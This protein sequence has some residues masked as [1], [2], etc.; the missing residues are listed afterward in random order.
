MR[1][2]KLKLNH[3]WSLGWLPL[4]VTFLMLSGCHTAM[5]TDGFRSL[6]ISSS[7]DLRFHSDFTLP[8]DHPLISELISQKLTVADK[9]G[10]NFSAAKIPIDVYLFRDADSFD[11]FTAKS[12]AAFANRRAFFLKN[13]SM[14]NVYAM[15]GDRV[16]EDLRHEVTHGYLHSVAPSLP[17]WIDE[18]LA[19]YFEVGPETNGLHQAHVRL[20]SDQFD[21]DLWAP[22][23]G[24]ME[25][26]YDP[27]TMTQVDYAEAWLWTHFL[28]SNEGTA[29]LVRSQMQR[30]QNKTGIAW[31]AKVHH[32]V[33]NPNQRLLEHLQE[34]AK[35]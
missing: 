23:L 26:L 5:I 24:R 32:L 20:L 3:F 7:K 16:A 35:R 17:L 34:L 10:L 2:T 12:N 9:T 22:S 29:A 4:L 1:K 30:Y 31:T 28:L 25:S 15:W 33:H 18:G 27:T 13:D 8:N 21:Q 14:L 6:D 19:E 11:K